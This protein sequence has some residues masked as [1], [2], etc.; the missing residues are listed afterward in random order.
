MKT[1]SYLAC[2]RPVITTSMD[3]LSS[4]INSSGVGISVP[5]DEPD[6]V[7]VAL[8]KLLSESEEE[9]ARRGA[10]AHA[11]V[12]SSYSWTRKAERV[13]GCMRSIQV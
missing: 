3:E 8:I 11:L 4:E 1:V 6:A 12:R 2:G 10:L 13:A 9:R 5:P 7:A